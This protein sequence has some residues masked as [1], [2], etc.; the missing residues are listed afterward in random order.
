MIIVFLVCSSHSSVLLHSDIRN[1]S[2][3]YDMTENV[4]S[5]QAGLRIQIPE[6]GST[7]LNRLFYGTLALT[8]SI[9]TTVSNINIS[10]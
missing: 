8:N 4:P 10:K 5:N 1:E 6:D 2:Y 9:G 7:N 3:K